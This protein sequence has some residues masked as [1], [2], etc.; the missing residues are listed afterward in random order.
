MR[1]S[2]AAA[3]GGLSAALALRSAGA[4]VRVYEQA[5]EIGEVGPGVGLFP[6]SIRILQRLGVADSITRVA[7]RDPLRG[8]APRR[9][10]LPR[11]TDDDPDRHQEV[12]PA[13]AH[14]VAGLRR[15]RNRSAI[16]VQRWAAVVSA[17]GEAAPDL[18]FQLKCVISDCLVAPRMGNG[19]F[20]P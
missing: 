17:V 20:V 10:R 12:R 3:S 9:R 4:T 1:W 13:S 11:R 16:T 18:T 14:L 5:A 8:A 15:N 19:S 7:G 2:S 6:N